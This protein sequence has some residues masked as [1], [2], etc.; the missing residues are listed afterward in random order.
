MPSVREL[1]AEALRDPDTY[2]LALEKFKA[3]VGERKRVV[4]GLEFAARVNKEIGIGSA[5]VPMGVT[6]I[7]ESNVDPMKLRA[8]ALR[9]LPLESQ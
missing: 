9:A 5:D 3:V 7:F 4:N 1:V 2:R 8:A 6:I